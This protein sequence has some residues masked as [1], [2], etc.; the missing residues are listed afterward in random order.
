MNNKNAN[1]LLSICIL[2]L[3]VF[4]VIASCRIKQLNNNYANMFVAVTNV[5]TEVEDLKIQ[6]EELDKEET[7]LEEVVE[8]EISIDW[9]YDYVLRVVAAE[10]RGEPIEG[11]MAVAQCIRTTSEATGQT[12]DQVVKV[13]NQYASPV[14]VDLVNDSVREACERVF[15]FGESITDE[16]IRY[17]YST[18]N[19][20]YSRWHE[21]NLTYVMTIGNHKFFKN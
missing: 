11:Q 5:Q 13:K 4:S 16:P 12:P 3:S 19:G 6:I 1:W 20:F 21:N 8:T 2:A 18:R 17:F 14:N 10:C 7:E 15:I 9:D